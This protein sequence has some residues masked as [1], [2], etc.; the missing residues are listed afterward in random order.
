MIRHGYIL[1]HMV[2]DPDGTP[3]R[4]LII[5]YDDADYPREAECVAS[6][7]SFDAAVAAGYLLSG[8]CFEDRYRVLIPVAISVGP[9]NFEGL[10]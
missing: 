1:G 3:A 8:K 7:S 5:R 9:V 4:H 2:G 6:C 10:R